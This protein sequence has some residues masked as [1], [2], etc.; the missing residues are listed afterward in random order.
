MTSNS[1][2][3]NCSNDLGLYAFHSGIANVGMGDGS[4]R[5]VKTATT[6]FTVAAMVTRANGEVYN[7]D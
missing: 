3:V 6:A 7:I 2:V 4:V 5:T 1:C